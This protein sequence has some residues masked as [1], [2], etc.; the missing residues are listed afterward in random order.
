MRGRIGA[1]GW[2]ALGAGSGAVA[3]VAV[4]AL[5][6]FTPAVCSTIGY[7]DVRPIR[8][9]LPA[10]TTDT[11]E[12]AACFDLNC[13]PIP[14]QP[15]SAGGF[16]VPQEPPYLVDGLRVGLTGVYVEVRD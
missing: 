12:V 13:K 16:A 7:Q 15:D 2:F 11:A 9:Q 6:T 8:L 10:G 5:W 1:R 4:V 14:L 3:V